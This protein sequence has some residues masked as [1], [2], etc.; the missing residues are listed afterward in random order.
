[1]KTEPLKATNM[2]NKNPIIDKSNCV[3]TKQ[4]EET[5]DEKAG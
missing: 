2:D 3:K 5:P 1:M 4:K